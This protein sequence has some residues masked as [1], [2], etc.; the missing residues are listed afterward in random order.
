MYTVTVCGFSVQ[1]DLS[2]SPHLILR[3]DNQYHKTMNYTQIKKTVNTENIPGMCVLT[4]HMRDLVTAENEWFSVTESSCFERQGLIFTSLSYRNWKCYSF[5]SESPTHYASKNRFERF[6][7]IK[8]FDKPTQRSV[9]STFQIKP[10]QAAVISPWSKNCN[11]LSPNS[12]IDST[13]DST[14]LDRIIRAFEP[15]LHHIT[16]SCT[17]WKWHIFKFSNGQ[18][19]EE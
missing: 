15:G 4:N 19:V 2:V 6:C 8:F 10:T 7:W 11:I 14:Y 5:L 13:A 3:V 9:F 18:A 16:W 12:P 1:L 17:F